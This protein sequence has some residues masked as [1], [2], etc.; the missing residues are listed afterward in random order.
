MPPQKGDRDG[1]GGA[2]MEERCHLPLPKRGL[3]DG[4]VYKGAAGRGEGAA[5][6]CEA[7]VR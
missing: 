6:R 5:R 2:G 3:S 4:P 7:E 1:V